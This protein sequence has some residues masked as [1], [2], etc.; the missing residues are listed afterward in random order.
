MSGIR[1]EH[2]L[3]DKQQRFAES[4]SKGM[5][6]ADAYRAAFDASNMKSATIRKRASELMTRGDI[7]GLVERL[8]AEG[9][10]AVEVQT[11]NDRDMLLTHLRDWASGKT[12][13]TATQLRAAELLGKA[14][15]LYRDVVEDHRERPA[16]VVA[17][18]LESKLSRLMDRLNGSP[19]GEGSTGD[20]DDQDEGDGDGPDDMEPGDNVH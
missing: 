11:V 14:C 2:G 19:V 7:R 4:V 12:D 3:T 1:N 10:K 13:A 15:G 8:V 9:R 20:D 17:A 16:T 6:L 18:E 5:G